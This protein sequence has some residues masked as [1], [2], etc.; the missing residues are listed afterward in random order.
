[1]QP[2]W[3]SS[4]PIEDWSPGFPWEGTPALQ[5][6]LAWHTPE[7]SST[8]RW[9]QSI[10]IHMLHH[11]LVAVLMSDYSNGRDYSTNTLRGVGSDYLFAFVAITGR[12]DR[13]DE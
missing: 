4:L 13:V 8:L 10:K 12:C 6:G 3:V 11:H 1:M 7:V 9:W 5:R 2:V